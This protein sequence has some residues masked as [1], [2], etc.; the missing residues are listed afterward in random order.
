MKTVISN[1]EASAY[2]RERRE[3]R[4]STGSFWAKNYAD[5][6]FVFSYETAIA[7]FTDGVWFINDTTYSITTSAHQSKVRS[8]L[9]LTWNGDNDVV[10]VTRVP[11]RAEVLSSRIGDIARERANRIRVSAY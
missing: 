4:N 3:F 10:T 2:I 5:G 1:R 8:A 9:N 7:Q 6:Y 11:R